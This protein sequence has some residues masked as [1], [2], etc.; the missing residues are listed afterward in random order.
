MWEYLDELIALILVIGCLCLWGLGVDSEVKSIC[1]MAA[2][3]AFGRG[4]GI[5]KTKKV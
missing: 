1:L 2:G 3:W 4:Y 5:A